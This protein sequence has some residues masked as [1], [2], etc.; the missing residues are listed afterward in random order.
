[1]LE[2]ILKKLGEELALEMKAKVPKVTGRT[3]DSIEV[4]SDATSF[5]ILGDAHIFNL[6]EGRKPTKANAVAGNPTLQQKIFEWIKAAG[7]TPREPSMS[8]L[9]LSWAISKSI[10][11]NGYK[12]KGN[13]FESVLTQRRID[14]I[15]DAL[16]T[17]VSEASSNII[18]K[19]DFK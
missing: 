3:A 2:E 17:K 19:L 6:I 9:S 1:M 14:S 4:E 7:I 10:H 18:N 12:G 16:L 11:K 13:F 15:S 5:T 8:Q